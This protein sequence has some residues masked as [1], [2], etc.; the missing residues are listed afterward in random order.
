VVTDVP[1][2]YTDNPRTNADAQ[3]IHFVDDI[4]ALMANIK[5]SSPGSHL[6]TG[7]MVFATVSVFKLTV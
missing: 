4:D 3:P 2:L 6:G 5:V 7:G 1:C